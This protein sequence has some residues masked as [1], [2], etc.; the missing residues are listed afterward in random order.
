MC[1]FSPADN[2]RDLLAVVCA[3]AFVALSLNAPTGSGEKANVPSILLLVS[4]GCASLVCTSETDALATG[5]PL[6]SRTVPSTEASAALGDWLLARTG[7]AKAASAASKKNRVARFCRYFPANL[8]LCE[9]LIGHG[10][11]TCLERQSR[12]V[13]TIR[14]DCMPRNGGSQCCRLSLE[15]RVPPRA[16]FVSVHSKEVEVF[17]FDAV[18]Q[19]FILRKLGR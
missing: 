17:C 12:L 11:F 1:F 6:A 13:F 8:G 7:I 4:M 10:R 2:S 9:A 14:G 3:S 18:S 15:P 5:L 19:L 16:N